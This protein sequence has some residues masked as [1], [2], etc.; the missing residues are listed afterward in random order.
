MRDEGDGY[1]IIGADEED[2]L[3]FYPIDSIELSEDTEWF[4]EGALF[5]ML[6]MVDETFPSVDIGA[7]VCSEEDGGDLGIWV[8]F[9]FGSSA[10]WMR[11]MTFSAFHWVWCSEEYN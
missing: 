6:Q 8:R 11:V 10:L 9:D 2:D 1:M 3:E 5:S 7:P 4:F